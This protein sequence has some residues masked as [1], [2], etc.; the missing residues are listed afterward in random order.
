MKENELQHH[1]I[2]GQKWGV[3][4]FQNKDG[5]LTAAGKRRLGIVDG[6]D[7]ALPDVIKKSRERQREAAQKVNET[8]TKTVNEAI[9]NKRK[10][11]F[12][13][14]GKSRKELNNERRELFDEEYAEDKKKLADYATKIYEYG[15]KYH[16]DLDDGGGGDPKAG[17]KYMEMWEQ[18]DTM[19][20]EARQKAGSRAT[21]R[22]LEK[23]GQKTVAKLEWKN[24]EAAV[25][26]VVGTLAAAVATKTA[27]SAYK[28]KTS[29]AELLARIGGAK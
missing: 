21:N 13:N 20:A 2:L 15:K 19:E 11:G 7:D 27:I 12:N 16:L 18:Y 23:Y 17:K 22:F 6:A 3:R 5:S 14:S 26:K 28:R 9:T 10:R 25:L 4:R 1:G 8:I 29:E 24:Q